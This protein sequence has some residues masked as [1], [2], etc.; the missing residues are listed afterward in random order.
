MIK[1]LIALLMFT[2]INTYAY[3]GWSTSLVY[4][5][6]SGEISEGKEKGNLFGF[7]SAYNYE[8]SKK[9]II[10]PEFGININFG[11][12]E[13][14]NEGYIKSMIP[15]LGVVRYFQP[16]STSFYP[17]VGLGAGVTIL[18]LENSEEDSVTN[19]TFRPSIGV[20][21]GGTLNVEL[22]YSIQGNADVNEGSSVF[23]VNNTT[24]NKKISSLSAMLTWGF[25]R[26]GATDDKIKE[27][28][29][30][31]KKMDVEDSIKK[32][33]QVEGNII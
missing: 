15:I 29:D 33:N 22:A 5:K 7:S 9:L 32:S 14:N 20:N 18:N 25:G 11:D 4:S 13:F 3:S 12:I 17:F 23:S 30:K 24:V 27:Q 31:L 6:V 8:L 10:G 2:S 16:V 19:F 28:R 21:F 1:L 26:A